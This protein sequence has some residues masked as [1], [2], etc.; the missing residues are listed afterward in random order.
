MGCA[1]QVRQGAHGLAPLYLQGLTAF[2]LGCAL[3][4]ATLAP[5]LTVLLAASFALATPVGILLG[6]AIS[7]SQMGAWSHL[8]MAAAAG[9]FVYVALCEVMP[10][11][12]PTPT[13]NPTPTPTPTPTPNRGQHRDED[14]DVGIHHG[15]GGGGEARLQVLGDLRVVLAPGCVREG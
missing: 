14:E 4:H 3:H 11:P 1:G 13:P 9:T 7:V 6:A 10:T 5:S 15:A 8:L 2:A 12:T